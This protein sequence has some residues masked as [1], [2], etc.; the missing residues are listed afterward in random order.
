MKSETVIEVDLARSRYGPWVDAVQGDGGTRSVAVK[1]L[2]R[3][4]PWHPP[5]NAEAAVAYKKPGGRK[6]L[7][8]KLPDGRQAVSIRGNIVTAIFAPQMLSIPGDVRASIVF[9]NEEMD[10]LTSFPFTVTVAPNQFAGAQETEDY[11]RLQWLEDKLDEYLKKA[12][13]SGVFNGP[14]GDPFTYADFTSE[15]LAALIG[16]RGSIGETGAVGPQGP[17]GVPGNDGK[18]PIKGVDYGTPE[19]IA[20]ISAQATT[21]VQT[22]IDGL[23][24]DLTANTASDVETQRRLDALWKLNQGISYQFEVDGTAFYS[25]TIPSGAKLA[26]VQKTGGRTIVWNQMVGDNTSVVT[27]VSGR[28]IVSRISGE[29]AIFTS[30]GT[31]IAVDGGTDMVFDSTLM[32]GSGSEPA[33][34]DEFRAMFPGEH[35]S[36]NSGELMPM[37]V[38][39]VVTRASDGTVSYTTE[40][41]S[42]V[43]MLDG[44]GDSAG[45]V[46]N[47]VDWETKTYHKR[48]G[49][50]DLGTLDYSRS[51]S[52]QRFEAI[53]AIPSLSAAPADRMPNV[54]CDLY[55]PVPY[56]SRQYPDMCIYINA[57][58]YIRIH[59]ASR[60]PLTR[61][62]FQAA[63]SGVILYYE[64][65][66]EVVTDISDLIGDT[67]QESVTVEAGGSNT[68][69]NSNGDNFRVPVPTSVEYLIS[70]AEVNQ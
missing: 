25:K 8:N 13:D 43:L 17:Q 51:S 52:P 12:K 50:V 36:Y 35:Y 37:P 61:N 26:S 2:D 48:V 38:N 7:Y 58:G 22:Q 15:Q 67:L 55:V 60:Y 57:N 32:F 42:A 59:D 5:R 64:L 1:L 45:N 10:Q 19:E 65:A 47:Y 63:M 66:Q 6:G 68:F 54:I 21:Q 9:N 70:L 16:P 41:P 40:I 44:Y 23:R 4:K 49:K 27:P 20:V 24:S 53:T 28:K 33:T 11:I 29:W 46:N 3:G 69:S 31:G 56:D 14:K 39:E 30:D 18:T 34:V 62:E